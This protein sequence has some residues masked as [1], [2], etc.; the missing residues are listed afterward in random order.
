MTDLT[1]NFVKAMNQTNQRVDKGK[2]RAV[3]DLEGASESTP[4]L[5]SSSRQAELISLEVVPMD[6]WEIDWPSVIRALLYGVLLT[7]ITLLGFLAFAISQLH[8]DL[9]TD[10]GVRWDLTGI[11]ILNVTLGEDGNPPAVDMKV[12]VLVQGVDFSYLSA[13]EQRMV[14]W[15][16]RSLDSVRVSTTAVTAMISTSDGMEDMATITVDPFN[17]KLPRTAD[18]KELVAMTARASTRLNTTRA[19]SLLDYTWVKQ[20]VIS[21]AIVRDI[22]V[23]GTRGWRKLISIG[24]DEFKLPLHYERTCLLYTSLSEALNTDH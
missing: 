22:K 21:T 23:E 5:A 1:L 6:H 7:L 8:R 9:T 18:A 4:L 10:E 20:K 14:T 3:D 24:L 2:Q 11:Q 12:E 13:W 15:G 16:I 19:L 17:L